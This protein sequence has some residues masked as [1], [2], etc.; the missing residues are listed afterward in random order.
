[1]LHGI[2]LCGG[3]SRRMGSPKALLPWGDVNLLGHAVRRLAGAQLRPLCAGPQEWTAGLACEVLADDPPAV[4][5]LGGISAGLSRGDCFVLGV[6]MPLLSSEEITRLVQ[7]GAEAGLALLPQV[8]GRLQ[9]LAAFWPRTLLPDLR[10][11]L[12]EGGRSVLGFLGRQATVCVDEA[13]L[14]RMGVDPSHFQGMNDPDAYR[15]LLKEAHG[16]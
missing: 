15:T 11:Y 10:R 9:P 8:A 5:P 2:V 4:G 7:A 13:G 16:G 14:L 1:M 3:L 6:D 12:D